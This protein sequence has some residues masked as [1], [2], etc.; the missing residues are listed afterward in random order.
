MDSKQIGFVFLL[1]GFLAG[2][3]VSV[4]QIDGIPWGQY[5]GCAGLMMMGLILVWMKLMASKDEVGVHDANL[6]A[7]RDTSLANQ[8][9]QVASGTPD[10]MRLSDANHEDDTDYG[11]EI[12]S[13]GN[14]S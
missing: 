11:E 2:S 10:F 14:R 8:A 5:A 4:S 12:G 1:A 9:G 7:L 13:S 3:Y 6:D